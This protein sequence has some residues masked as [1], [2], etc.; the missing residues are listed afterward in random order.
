MCDDALTPCA[1]SI[2]Q[3]IGD[4]VISELLRLST[5][6]LQEQTSP[7]SSS[8]FGS[9]LRQLLVVMQQDVTINPLLNKLPDALGGGFLLQSLFT[10]LFPVPPQPLAV[11]GS[12]DV[13][14]HLTNREKE[15]LLEMA[16]GHTNG[17]I[18]ENLFISKGT[19]HRHFNNIFAKLKAKNATEAVLK[20][21]AWGLIAFDLV[22]L[23]EP[24]SDGK[25][26]NF[27]PVHQVLLW[28]MNPQAQEYVG[29]IMPQLGQLGL[30]LFLTTALLPQAKRYQEEQDYAKMRQGRIFEYTPDGN[31]LRTLDGEGQFCEPRGLAF[32]P[33]IAKQ[34]GFQ[35]GNLYV[36]NHRAYP[37]PL[38]TAGILELTPQGKVVRSFTGGRFLSSRLFAP[39]YLTFTQDGKL[40]VGSG[41]NTDAILEFTE[42]GNQ[43]R[44]FANLV[45]YGGMTAGRDG[46]LYVVGGGW[47]RVPVKVFS[48]QGE[49]LREIGD[50]PIYL[51]PED[52]FY[53]DVAVSH[54][55]EVFVANVRYGYIEIYDK[56]G[57]RIGTI[58]ESELQH[59]CRLTCSPNGILY[60]FDGIPETREIEVRGYDVAHKTWTTRFSAPEGISLCHLAVGINGNLFLSGQQTLKMCL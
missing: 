51:P 10:R 58:G 47:Y 14:P 2:P 19:V 27:N 45:P 32:A 26:I 4:E 48:S 42:G 35:P 55:G 43:V 11:P 33:R 17:Q 53:E 39:N 50:N 41:W 6:W 25:R 8:D 3:N 12:S 29:A 7:K 20:A 1:Y 49:L 40:M 15:V 38:N 5:G 37:D 59:P 44:R 16:Q 18:A 34:H 13:V 22:T 56:S 52:R 30:L 21:G 60:I 28:T 31:L 54:N 24:M 57:K 46:N 36:I 9:L 23:I